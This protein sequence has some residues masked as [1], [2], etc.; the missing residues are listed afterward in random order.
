[1]QTLGRS[2]SPDVFATLEVKYTYILFKTDSIV[3]AVMLRHV[4]MSRSTAVFLDFHV[5]Q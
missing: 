2:F 5:S 1:M 4:N 3:V